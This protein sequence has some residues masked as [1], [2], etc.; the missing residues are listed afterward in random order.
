M[1]NL[2]DEIANSTR[3]MRE[4]CMDKGVVRASERA[5]VR[6]QRPRNAQDSRAPKGGLW[7]SQTPLPPV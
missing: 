3:S 7:G 2:R 4:R 5:P 6:S 1:S